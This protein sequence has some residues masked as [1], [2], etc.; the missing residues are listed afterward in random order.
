VKL[1]GEDE[2]VE[3]DGAS[4]VPTGAVLDTR[5][6]A[7]ALTAAQDTAGKTA[8]ATFDGGVFKVS[9]DQGA[10]P[11]TELRLQGSSFAACRASGSR[12]QA[13]RRP[14]R[15]VWGSGHGRFRTRGRDGAATVRG[16]VWLTEDTCAGTRVRVRRGVV[17]VRDFGR[18]RT[19]KVRAGGSYLARHRAR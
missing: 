5:K 4:A 9:Q 3:L 7:V 6:G 14:R 10:R 8:T 12:A 19:V 11:V 16:T 18:G 2:Y 15:R 1:P 13:S 17:D